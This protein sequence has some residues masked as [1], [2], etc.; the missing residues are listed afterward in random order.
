[1][2]SKKT[3]NV[4]Q[5]KIAESVFKFY[6]NWMKTNWIVRWLLILIALVINI[7]CD[8][9]SKNIVRHRIGDF[10]RIFVIENYFTL[11]KIEN[12]GAFLSVGESLP[13]PWRLLILTVLPVVVLGIGLVY[14]FAKKDLSPLTQFAICLMI[15]GGIGNIYDRIVHGSVT[16]FMHIDFIFFQTGIFNMADVSIMTGMFI[17]LVNSYLNRTAIL[18]EQE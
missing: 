14:L 13:D 12:S 4:R 16:D 18:H 1:M 11:T 10:E 5:D 17:L 9:V 15:G 6:F 3:E 2:N 8:Q 7:G